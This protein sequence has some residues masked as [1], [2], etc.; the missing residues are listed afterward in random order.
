MH[1]TIYELL[2]TNTVKNSTQFPKA[3][4]VPFAA[5]CFIWIRLYV[6]AEQWSEK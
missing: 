6:H 1:V 2:L 5:S 3:V 4:E